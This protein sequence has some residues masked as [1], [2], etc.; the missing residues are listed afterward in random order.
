MVLTQVF[1]DEVREQ[2]KQQISDDFTFVAVGTDGTSPSSSDTT[3][4]NEVLR[5]ERQ[6]TTSGTDYRIVSMWINS[7]EANGN[8]LQEVGTFNQSSNGNMWTRNTFSSL[9][10]TDTVE[11]WIDVKVVIS[12]SEV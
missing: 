9:S 1:L 8:D 3:L 4:G 6:E 2:I 5:K 12:V 7:V 10:K 11:V